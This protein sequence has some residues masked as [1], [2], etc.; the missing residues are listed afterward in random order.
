MTVKSSISLTNE[1]HAFAKGLVRAGRYASVSAVLQQGIEML[2]RK[3][4]RED[5]EQDALKLLLSRRR[6]GDFFGSDAMGMRVR[7][8]AARKRRAHGLAD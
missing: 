7:Q 5:A 8:M 3:T 6:D 1:Q 4:E 2:R